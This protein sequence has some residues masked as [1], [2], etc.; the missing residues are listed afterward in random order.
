[1]IGGR[2]HR[3]AHLDDPRVR[4]LLGDLG[5][6]KDPAVAGLRALRDLDLDHLDLRVGGVLRE[7]FGIEVAVGCATAEVAGTDLPDQVAAGFAVIAGDRSLTGVVGEVT[8]LGP[9]VHRRHGRS[10]QCAEAHG[11]DVEH[12]GRVGLGTLRATDRHPQVVLCVLHHW[13]GCD[14]VRHPGVAVRVHVQFGSEWLLV[15]HVLGP[16]VDERAD[17]PV[18]RPPV[19]VVLHEVLVEFGTHVLEEEP[20]V[21]RQGKVPQDAV[22]L[23]EEVVDPQQGERN[24]DDLCKQV[25]GA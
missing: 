23:L 9:G 8:E 24:Q 14:R 25:P 2:E 7:Q 3:L 6:R 5:A 4:Y 20:Q 10:A 16:L 17:V 15:A 19:G 22:P 12:G 18:E 11:G 13:M 21:A 1:M